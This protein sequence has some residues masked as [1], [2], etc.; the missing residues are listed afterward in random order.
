MT[1]KRKQKRAS[2]SDLVDASQISSGRQGFD[3]DLATFLNFA[4]END[5]E[6]ITRELLEIE[7]DELLVG[8]ISKVPESCFRIAMG[9]PVLLEND[10]FSGKT[11]KYV[12]RA[13]ELVKRHFQ[14]LLDHPHILGEIRKKLSER[15]IERSLMDD[16]VP[17]VLVCRSAWIVESGKLDPRV[18]L[19]LSSID[20]Q[21]KSLDVVYKLD[22]LIL[23]A[24]AIASALSAEIE[25]IKA[26]QSEGGKF[27]D[28]ENLAT[29]LKKL[30]NE[31]GAI[32][33]KAS[34]SL[35]DLE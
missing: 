1:E 7:D 26:V 30:L 2:A 9:L 28:I 20:G 10:A 19:I 24:K 15:N 12:Q 31:T 13:Q 5:L 14:P 21:E 23:L 8:E 25:E 22:D 29:D 18:R 11:L 27:V 4:T 6:K 16:S 3:E 17:S 32:C 34:K 35:S 33:D